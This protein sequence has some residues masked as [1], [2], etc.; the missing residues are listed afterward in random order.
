MTRL[1][2]ST[3]PP[4]FLTSSIRIHCPRNTLTTAVAANSAAL[5]LLKLLL[6]RF[7]S[8]M[9]ALQVL[10]QAVTLADKLLLPLSESVLL[11]LHLLSESLPQALFLF[12]ELGVVELSWSSLAE[13][14]CLH[15]LSTVGFVVCFFGRV[16]E[17]QHVGSDQDR[18]KLLEIAVV[19]IL[20]FGNTPGVLTSLDNAAIASLDVLLGAN[21]GKW[22]SGHKASRMLGGSLVVFL[23]GRCVDLDTLGLDDSANL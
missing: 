11:N 19:F 23:D 17:V 22:H 6:Q 8:S 3:T 16:D 1:Q 20:D 15:L 2:R 18:A 9:R 12:L 4:S 5:H 10:V 7:N 13:F 21:D 14:A